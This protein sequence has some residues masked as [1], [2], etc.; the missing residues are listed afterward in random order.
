VIEP[1]LDPGQP[2]RLAGANRAE[3]WVGTVLG[4]LEHALIPEQQGSLLA[5]FQLLQ[6]GGY[7]LPQE[8]LNE[9]RGPLRT[10]QQIREP[11]GASRGMRGIQEVG[12][13]LTQQQPVWPV[14]ETHDRLNRPHQGSHQPTINPSVK[15]TQQ[16]RE[17]PE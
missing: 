13:Q 14:P 1:W 8:L 10:A 11:F 2:L 15:G 7:L 4:L 12:A 5:L 17:K 6:V 9:L 16:R 3:I